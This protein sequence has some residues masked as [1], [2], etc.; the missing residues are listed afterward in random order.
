[1]NTNMTSAEF[2]KQYKL[3][4]EFTTK[5]VFSKSKK[6]SNSIAGKPKVLT[7]E[8]IKRFFKNPAVIVA[9][10]IFL[11]I[12]ILAIV[13]SYGSSYHAQVRIDQDNPTSFVN[14]LPPKF[15]PYKTD[16]IPS[17]AAEKGTVWWYLKEFTHG[18]Y[19]QY[20]SKYAKYSI[21]KTSNNKLFSYDAYSFWHGYMLWNILKATDP[22][23]LTQV[24]VDALSSTIP[25]LH[26]HF[27]TTSRMF[28]IWT[29][30]WYDALQSIKIAFLVATIEAVIGIMVGAYLGFHAG[31]WL[32]TIMMR[33][34][35]IFQAPP[36]IIWLLMFVS[37]W[38]EK[39]I[40]LICGLLFV[41][42]TWPIGA[43]RMFIITVKDE[44]YIVASKSVGASTS[45]QIFAHALPAI[46]GKVAMNYVRRI[47]AVIM[48]IAS[49]AFLGFFGASDSTNIGAF[50]FQNLEQ[51]EQNA[52]LLILPATILLFL[53]LSMQFIALGLHDALDPRVVKVK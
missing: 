14:D 47:P 33:V 16:K 1:M 17:A 19:K 11:T 7:V 9:T 12:L 25:E 51:S 36:S 30:V 28:D 32:D 37:L 4:K 46:L 43:T 35:E 2:N 23:T 45:R 49:L 44:E 39:D 15:S 10:I 29:S 48:S 18:P 22:D 31:K 24:Q 5:I 8:I 27:G 26:T 20:L 6:N 3:T 40:V 38:G 52:W 13:A 42:W 53:S 34:I 41:G 50:M 21:D